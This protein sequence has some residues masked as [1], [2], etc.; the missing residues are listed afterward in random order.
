M[1]RCGALLLL[2]SLWL[3]V[4]SGQSDIQAT[5]L[6]PLTEESWTFADNGNVYYVGKMSGKVTVARGGRPEPRPDDI[7]PPPIVNKDIKWFTL[8]VD[9]TSLAQAVYRTDAE[10]RQKLAGAGVEFRTY[11]VTEADIDFLNLRDIVTRVG[12]PIVVTQ[13]K[14]GNILDCRKVNS[15]SDWEKIVKG[16]VP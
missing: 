11:L 16:A 4:V 2:I 1:K 15:Q 8:I 9:P 3:P 12:L 13:D 5:S 7:K 14:D 10:A 6:P